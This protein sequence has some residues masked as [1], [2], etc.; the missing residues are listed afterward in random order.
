M[1]VGTQED[2]GN[3]I[4]V[5]IIRVLQLIYFLDTGLQCKLAFLLQQIRKINRSALGE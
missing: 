3:N 5:R 2:V 1:G 4:K